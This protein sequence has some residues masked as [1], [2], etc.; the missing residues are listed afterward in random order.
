MAVVEMESLFS[1]SLQ[2]FLETP[3]RIQSVDQNKVTE[4]TYEMINVLEHIAT[5]F[6][7]FKASTTE[8][9]DKIEH[10][11]LENVRRH[12]KVKTEDMKQQAVTK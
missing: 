5:D 12:D 10:L 1:M 9:V 7:G 3:S 2:S 8:R 4:I 11:T 6:Q